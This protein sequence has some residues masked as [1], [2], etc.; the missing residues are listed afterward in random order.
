M[1]TESRV[2][3]AEAGSRLQASGR[4][5][6][7][8]SGG[9]PDEQRARA[10]EAER[11]RA[12]E[13]AQE[14]RDRLAAAQAAAGLVLPALTDLSS[15]LGAGAR[16]VVLPDAGIR[17]V[18]RDPDGAVVLYHRSQEIRLGDPEHALAHS[19]ALAAGLLA[20]STR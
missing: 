20:V 7:A 18:A 9:R 1:Q 13:Q 14:L 5:S 8:S 19:R 4:R 17:V 10:A 16:G 12:A 2:I 11:E 15:D 6:G 3:P